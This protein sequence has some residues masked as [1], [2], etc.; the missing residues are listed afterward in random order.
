MGATLNVS[1]AGMKPVAHDLRRLAVNA[2]N[3]KPAMEQVAQLAVD[4]VRDQFETEGSHF[5]ESQWAALSPRYK[6]WKQRVAPGKPILELTGKLR[7]Y[8]APTAAQNAGFYK[9]NSRLMEVGVLYRQV[10]YAKYHQEGG[11]HLPARPIMGE[12]TMGDQKAMSAVVHTHLM[13]GVR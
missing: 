1:G 3:M 10:P 6:V 13:Q 7:R 9:A 11:K 4:A 12:L 8:V 5:G 2:R